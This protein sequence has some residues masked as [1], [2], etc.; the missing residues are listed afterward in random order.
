MIPI[1]FLTETQLEPA[2]VRWMHGV[3]IRESFGIDVR[4]HAAHAPPW[5]GALGTARP[6]PGPGLLG[7]GL[8]GPGLLGRALPAPRLRDATRDGPPSR[9]V[10]S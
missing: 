4:R 8:L 2:E 3:R 9:S 5:H 1:I 10:P 7:P 6:P